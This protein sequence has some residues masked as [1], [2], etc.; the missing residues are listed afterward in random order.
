[1]K[2]L[3]NVVGGGTKT[4]LRRRFTKREK[5]EKKKIKKKKCFF[6]K[7]STNLSSASASLCH[8]LYSPAEFFNKF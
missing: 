2:E 8:L 1:L 5:E 4:A 3:K 7:F 6:E